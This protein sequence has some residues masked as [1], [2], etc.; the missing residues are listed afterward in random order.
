MIETFTMH[1][2]KMELAMTKLWLVTMLCSMVLGIS[3]GSNAADLASAQ[4][5]PI[6]TPPPPPTP[7]INGA[8]TFGVRP[9]RPLLFTIP[10]TGTEPITYSATGLPE[11][12]VLDAKLGRL[13]GTAPTTPGDYKITLGA[14]N[15]LGTDSKP[16]LIRVGDQICLTPPMG[17]NSWNCFAGA[18]DQ[19]KVAAA[20]HAMVDRGLIKHGW[21]YINIDDTWQGVRG[22]SFNGIQG[23][24]KF[25]D[26]KQLCDEIH[27]LGLKA[28]IYSTPWTTSYAD[29]VGGSAENP[30][31]AWSK[32]TISKN[33]II[34]KKVLPWAV[35]KYSFA[36]NDAKQWASWGFDYLKYDWNPIETPQVRE[37]HDALNASGRDV[38]LSLSN[39]APFAGA[40]D[41]ARLSNAWRTSGDI[42]D[43]WANM[44]RIGFSQGRWNPYGGPGHWNDPDMLVVGMVGW[45]PRLHATHLT[46]DE[47]YTHISLWCLLSA[48]LLIGCDMTQMDD[49]TLSL[50]TNDEVLAVDQDVL[51]KS[52]L[53]I[54]KDNNLEVWAKPLSDGAWAVGLFNRGEETATVA[55]K[56]D[57]LKLTGSQK[58]RDLWRQKD[59]GAADGQFAS[60]VPPHRLSC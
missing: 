31:G 16:L 8:R 24:Q 35:G 30:D 54:S 28:G 21:T 34:N 33:G 45:G 6:L 41:W 60:T 22:G 9:G 32:P 2:F 43:T 15:A 53:R 47:Q 44:S 36:T 12:V 5:A 39:S 37:M 17:W 14:R 27:S 18:V 57:S 1:A 20:A 55:V 7:R 13:S 52:A 3:T 38:V 23:N 58:V 46:P 19:E 56:F 4:S 59:L 49:F 42:R 26:L 29:H 25:P 10:A 11:G 51:G 50:L 40:S 48:P